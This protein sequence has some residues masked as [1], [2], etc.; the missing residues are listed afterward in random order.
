[1]FLLTTPLE[2]FLEK[3]ISYQQF[4]LNPSLI[5]DPNL[6]VKLG[7]KYVPLRLTG[8]LNQNLK[9][10]QEKYGKKTFYREREV[11]FAFYSLRNSFTPTIYPLN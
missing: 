2:Q 5:D 7:T 11:E 4:S 6:V 10:N 8:F 1:M 3:A 9:L